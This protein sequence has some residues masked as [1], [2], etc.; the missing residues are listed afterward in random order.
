M[1][2]GT[3]GVSITAGPIEATGN[4]GHAGHQIRM[5][6][7]GSFFIHIDSATAKQ[8]I[9]ELTPIAEEK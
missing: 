8:W 5:G 3:V 1:T 7:G 2:A 4:T 9:A 6:S